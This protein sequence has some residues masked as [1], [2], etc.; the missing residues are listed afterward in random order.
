[1]LPRVIDFFL[2]F[3]NLN[4]ETTM[5]GISEIETA[6][7]ILKIIFVIVDDKNLALCP[8]L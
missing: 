7:Y 2:I 6:S 1:M 3:G 8:I 5:G 4:I